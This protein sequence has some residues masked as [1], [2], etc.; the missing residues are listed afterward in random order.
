MSINT[1]LVKSTELAIVYHHNQFVLDIVTAMQDEHIPTPVIGAVAE[2]LLQ[3]PGRI[4]WGCTVNK[5]VVTIGIPDGDIDSDEMT[6]VI[7]IDIT[8]TIITVNG[9]PVVLDSHT[10]L[11]LMNEIEYG[12]VMSD[13]EITTDEAKAAM[14]ISTAEILAAINPPVAAVNSPLST[15]SALLLSPDTVDASQLPTA[16]EVEIP[17]L[18]EVSVNAKSLVDKLGDK[19]IDTVVVTQ[20]MGDWPGGPARVTTIYPDPSCPEIVFEV[21]SDRGEIGVFAEESVIVP[22]SLLT[23]K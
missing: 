17:P 20:A 3:H 1:L 4:W 22:V 21:S 6:T 15:L 12:L 16:A 11:T 10:I 14:V 8:D 13:D 18:T 19:L 5:G 23:D 2:Y 9:A 7:T